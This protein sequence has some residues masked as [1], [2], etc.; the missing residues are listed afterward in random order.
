MT[1][2]LVAFRNGD[3]DELPD[4]R[5]VFLEAALP[6]MSHR[7]KPGLDG[8]GILVHACAQCH[9]PRL[10]DDISR[11][12][13]DVMNLDRMS[14]SEKDLAIERM[15]LAKD[16]RFLMPPKLFRELSDDEIERAIA[17]LER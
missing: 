16:D 14:R 7:P 8:K 10:P 3:T 1:G 5:D 13:F 12:R 6:G 9:N 2:A 11:A 15:K 17:E 4:I